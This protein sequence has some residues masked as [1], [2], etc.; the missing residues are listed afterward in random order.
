MTKE[1]ELLR[2]ATELLRVWSSPLEALAASGD[3]L[4]QTLELL[5][6]IRQREKE[7]EEARAK[8][9]AE[10]RASSPKTSQMQLDAMLKGRRKMIREHEAKHKSAYDELAKA[11]AEMATHTMRKWRNSG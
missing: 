11:L 9:K 3:L 6:D 5:A 4:P 1:K 2:R 7:L 10:Q 8:R